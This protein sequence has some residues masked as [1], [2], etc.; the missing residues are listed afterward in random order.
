[1]PAPLHGR[2]QGV[3][4][5]HGLVPLGNGEAG[6]A[7]FLSGIENG[8]ALAV[9]EKMNKPEIFYGSPPCQMFAPRPWR[10]HALR[11]IKA[12][13][14]AFWKLFWESLA[15]GFGIYLGL[16]ISMRLFG[17]EELVA[18]LKGLIQP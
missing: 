15:Q 18:I 8:H 10:E 6:S 12:S 1:M 2:I 16:W 5:N 3:V 4:S 14:V 7:V 17:T 13:W 11:W 9:G